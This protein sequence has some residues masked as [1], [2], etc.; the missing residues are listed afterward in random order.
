[1]ASRRHTLLTQ[2]DCLCALQATIPHLSRLVLHCYFQRH[3]ISR[4]PLNED[5][6]NS[7]K[8]KFKGC[9]IGYR[10]TDFTEVQT[11]EGRSCRPNA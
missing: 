1:M 10:H 5:G 7:P 2:D 9:L 6:Q 8:K 3:G 4:L 11:E